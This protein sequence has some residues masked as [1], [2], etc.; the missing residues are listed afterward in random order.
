MQFVT[1]NYKS[2]SFEIKILQ[3][4]SYFILQGRKKYKYIWLFR[5]NKFDQSET[6]LS[7]FHQ[8]LSTPIMQ[9]I[10]I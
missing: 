4:L 10:M 9:R 8:K 6:V 5:P 7:Y 2:S 1:T 3:E